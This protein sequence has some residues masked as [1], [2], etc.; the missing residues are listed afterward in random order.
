MSSKRNHHSS[1]SRRS[2]IASSHRRERH[3]A[4]GTKSKHP[5]VEAASNRRRSRSRSRSPWRTAAPMKSTFKVGFGERRVSPRPRRNSLGTSPVRKK[6]APVNEL[7]AASM[8]VKKDQK[9]KSGNS[10]D[11]ALSS[12]FLKKYD[13]LMIHFIPRVFRNAD[14]KAVEQ[15]SQN[16]GFRVGFGRSAIAGRFDRS[17][18]R[19]DMF[20]RA[21]GFAPRRFTGVRDAV[22]GRNTLGRIR[23][24]EVQREEQRRKGTEDTDKP[25]MNLFD[26]CKVPTGKS[27]FTHD[28]RT[29]K[30]TRPRGMRYSDGMER[31]RRNDRAPIGWRNAA[32]AR[33]FLARDYGR[34]DRKYGDTTTWRD[35]RRDGRSSSEGYRRYGEEGRGSDG[36][37]KHDL[38]DDDEA[39]SDY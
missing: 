38:F 34:D 3:D 22:D 28:D 2:P 9:P 21:P 24:D 31:Q 10:F 36:V 16:G 6:P 8:D 13:N 12:S 23:R 18:D 14:K 30:P 29:S 37:W 17:M 11:A 35:A 20:R 26:P 5:R 39:N 32:Q 1:S 27:Y 25:V 33:L 7:D 19:R 15:F 4:A